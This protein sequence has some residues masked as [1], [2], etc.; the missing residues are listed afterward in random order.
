MVA[1]SAARAA[2][3]ASE[4]AQCGLA[5]AWRAAIDDRAALIVATLAPAGLPASTPRLTQLVEAL[6]DADRPMWWLANAV[7][8]G[9]LPMM[10]DVARSRRTHDLDG[11]DAAVAQ[12]LREVGAAAGSRDTAPPMVEVLTGQVLV[13][14]HITHRTTIATGIQRVVRES[15]RRWTVNYEP[16]LVGWTDDHLA[17]RRLNDEEIAQTLTGTNVRAGQPASPKIEAD[18]ASQLRTIPWQGV[19]LEPEVV[20]ETERAARIESLGADSNVTLSVLAYD[21]VPISSAETA[22]YGVSGWFGKY[23]SALKYADR[24]IADSHSAAGEFRG[25]RRMLGAQGL[26]GPDIAGLPL[27]SQKQPVDAQSRRAAEDRLGVRTLPL[28]LCV[29]SHEP[30]KNHL[31][32]LH[33][34]EI[35]WRSGHRFALTFVGGNGWNSGSFDATVERMR[36]AGRPVETVRALSDDLLWASYSIARCVVFPSLHEGFGLPVAEALAAGTPVITSNFGSMAEIAAGGGALT[37]DPRD[38][39][40]LAHALMRLLSDD[41]LHARLHEEA[42]NRTPWTWDDYSAQVWAQLV[43]GLQ[44]SDPHAPPV[45]R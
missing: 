33:A 1:A 20:G 2:D 17:L 41:A 37:V 9:Q 5:A 29:G 14:V 21:C 42:I 45:I 28:V 30:R 18:P 8:R 15:V 13:D 16:V 6:R 44:P 19:F 32:L 25:L 31:A 34:A 11:A 4:A 35:A 27:P 38:D 40:A 26:T 22:D 3:A 23:I 24:L 36:T 39:H 12:I 43:F 10:A 7:L